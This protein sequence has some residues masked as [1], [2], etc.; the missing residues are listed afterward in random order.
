MLKHR[1]AR[2]SPSHSSASFS[3]PSTSVSAKTTPPAGRDQ[4]PARKTRALLARS[5]PR[6]ALCAGLAGAAT[7]LGY[8]APVVGAAAIAILLGIVLRN[9]IFLLN[10][11][12]VLIFPPIGRLS[13]F[14]A[15]G[16]G[17][18][19]GTAINDTPSVVAAGY[20]FGASAGHAEPSLA[21]P[22]RRR[23]MLDWHRT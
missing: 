19:A 21:A 6:V 5:L 23:V 11:A 1:P 4:R 16:F 2:S 13:G 8:L 17:P 10:V 20:S 14:S 7:A 15:H 9:T 22:G 18:W 12:G 3:S